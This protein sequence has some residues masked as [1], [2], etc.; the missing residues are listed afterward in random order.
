MKVYFYNSYKLSRTG[1]QCLEADVA[2]NTTTLMTKENMNNFSHDVV[3]YFSMGGASMIFEKTDGKY[4]F[5]MK[6]ITYADKEKQE[7][8]PGSCWYYNFAMLAE[9]NEAYEVCSAAV[10]ALTRYNDLKDRL[11]Q[12]IACSG[13]EISYEIDMERLKSFFAETNEYLRGDVNNIIL[14]AD[15]PIPFSDNAF[16]KMIRDISAQNISNGYMFIVF[17]RTQEYFELMYRV[18]NIR[19]KYMFSPDGSLCKSARKTAPELGGKTSRTA[20]PS[21]PDENIDIDMLVKVACGVVV[22][23]AASYAVIKIVKTIMK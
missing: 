13:G 14:N 6:S 2:D 3:K 18:E 23:A 15:K 7:N 12:I 4:L 9:E 21:A 19:A 11:H 5:C 8:E 20:R 1:F 10:Y 17:S 16:E 22:V